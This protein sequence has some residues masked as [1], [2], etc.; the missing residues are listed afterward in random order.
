M[1][2][3][4]ADATAA[5]RDAEAMEHRSSRLRGYQSASPHLIIWGIVWAVG[6]A[7]SYLQLAWINAIWLALVAVGTAAS[8][9]AG[10]ADGRKGVHAEGLAVL[11][12]TFVVFVAGTFIVM[13]P[14]DPRQ[15][16]AFFP[17]VVAAGYAIMGAMGATR[18]LI[19]AG[20]LAALTLGG[21]IELGNLFLPWMAVVGGGGLVLGGVWLRQP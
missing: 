21:F 12:V 11:G 4:Q 9:V 8:I 6:Y 15:P 7:A 2:L 3:T 14:H 17:L 18:M 16:A 5:L 19:I 20:A 13:A 1:T 10:M